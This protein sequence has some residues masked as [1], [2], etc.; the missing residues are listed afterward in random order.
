MTDD[1]E[2]RS[3]R[4][5]ADQA[6]VA[7]EGPAADSQPRAS[8]GPGT[9]GR[10]DRG[11]PAHGDELPYIDDPFS[12]VWVLFLIAVFGA[13]LL[14]GI[15]FGRAGLLSPTPTPSPTPIVTPSPAVSPSPPIS[16][17]P[18]VSP[19]PALSPTPGD[20]TPDASTPAPS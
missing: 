1:Q 19:T 12:R 20:E 8:G 3:S 6:R 11:A 14:Y 10:D 9:P 4:R 18:V 7:E 16:P 2:P 13:I 17:T 5:A 15:L